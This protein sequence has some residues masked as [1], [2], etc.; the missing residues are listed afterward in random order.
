MSFD[1][2]GQEWFKKAVGACGLIAIYGIGFIAL[3]YFVDACG[4]A[5]DIPEFTCV[6]DGGSR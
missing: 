1:T 3:M 2:E 4:P 5:K 6:C